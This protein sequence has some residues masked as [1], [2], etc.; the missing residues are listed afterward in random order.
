MR[1]DYVWKPVNNDTIDR[2]NEYKC[3]CSLLAVGEVPYSCCGQEQK[4]K[5]S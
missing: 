5:L 1:N 4:M 2:V 3:R